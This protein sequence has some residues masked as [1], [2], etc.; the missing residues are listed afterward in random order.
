MHTQLPFAM[1]L[2]CAAA[3]A[4]QFSVGVAARDITPEPGLAM[5]GY[6]DRLGPATGTLDPLYAKA[7][8]FDDGATAVAL[9]TLDLGRVPLPEV[10]DRIRERIRHHNVHHLFI[11]ASHT[12]QAPSLEADIPYLKTLEDR[13]VDCVA[14]AVATKA[15]AHI[16]VGRT[17]IDVG[18]NRRKLLPDGRVLMKWRNEDR[19]P[20]PGVVDREA[21]LIKIADTAGN[22]R[23]VL[24]HYACHPVVLGGDHRQY[25]A[26]F[27]GE[28]ARRVSEQTG[29]ECLFLQGACG[30]INPY[31]DKTP[32]DQGGI[33]SMRAV[34]KQCADAVLAALGAIATAAPEQPAV[35]ISERDIEVGL[36]WDL[37]DPET[38]KVIRAAYGRRYELIMS[39]FKPDHHVPLS[40]L[41]LNNNLAFVG[42][43]GEVF[44]QYQLDLKRDSPLPDTFL[45]GYTNEYHAYFPTVKDAA[46]GGYGGVTAT[47]VGLGAA[48]K[49]ATQ[50]LIDIG[51]MTG[52]LHPITAQD[53][54]LLEDE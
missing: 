16:G 22:L 14:E 4:A 38:E 35:G 5:W 17:D 7:V 10:C 12:H 26:D 13:V 32:V 18:F 31:L 46:A 50:A 27:C 21:A 47:Y 20:T 2:T 49:L 37:S 53:F 3:G 23:A 6:S 11:T 34:G 54:V 44:V 40:V 45:V 42:M 48:D 43:P 30:D 29:A 19:E 36:R 1:L 25:S 8:V 33:E 24:V 28:M 52:Q 9:V 15:P 51:Q 39:K 41:V